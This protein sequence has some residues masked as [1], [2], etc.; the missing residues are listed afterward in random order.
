[1]SDRRTPRRMPRD[2]TPE[3]AQCIEHALPNDEPLEILR[4]VA[5]ERARWAIEHDPR[6][7]LYDNTVWPAKSLPTA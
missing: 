5:D 6:R 3:F 2:I 1:M 4:D 7:R